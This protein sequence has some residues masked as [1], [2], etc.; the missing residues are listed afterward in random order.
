VAIAVA[1]GPDY[2]F[3]RLDYG[4]VREVADGIHW[5]RMPLPFAL[6]HINLWLLADGDG[7]TVIDTGYNND[8]TRDHWNAL[9]GHVLDGKPIKRLIV[10]HFHPDHAS[11]AGWFAERWN[12]P[13]WMTYSE[14][15]QAQLNRF[16]GPTADIDARMEFYRENGMEKAGIDGYRQ[17]RPDFSQI[18]LPLP[19][20]FRRMMDGD[21]FAIGDDDWQVITGAGHSPEHAALWCAER[22]ILISG[23]QVLPRISTNVSLQCNEPDG[24]PLR[25]YLD[26]LEKFRPVAADALVLPSHDRPFYGLHERIDDLG[27]HHEERL[28][29]AYEVCEKPLTARELIPYLFKRKLDQHQLGFAI[30]EALAHANYLV[31]DGRLCKQRDADG[32][33]RYRQTSD[34]PAR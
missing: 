9:F 33:I 10:S 25:L 26:S 24:D 23:D 34:Y 16:G 11:L 12:T 7:W 21:V 15:M 18:I 20:G 13:I 27:R 28:T 14:W 17:T 22:N 6:N 8:E 19:I 29:I 5:I 31:A 1:D 32:I 2:P 3:D 4:A 30:G